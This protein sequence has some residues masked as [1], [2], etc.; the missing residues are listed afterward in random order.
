M[1]AY[2]QPA[3]TSRPN[4]AN[5]GPTMI[6]LKRDLLKDRRFDWPYVLR[7]LRGNDGVAIITFGNIYNTK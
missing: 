4:E 7:T 5:L 6:R 1:A 2:G 3:V